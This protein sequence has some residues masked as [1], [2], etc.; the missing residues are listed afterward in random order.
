MICL[1]LGIQLIYFLLPPSSIISPTAIICSLFVLLIHYLSSSV[2]KKLLW[3]SFFLL[4][5]SPL[6]NFPVQIHTQLFALISN[7]TDFIYLFILTT[8]FLCQRGASQAQDGH[9]HLQYSITTIFTQAISESSYWRQQPKFCQ[10]GKHFRE[11]HSVFQ[12]EFPVKGITQGN[13]N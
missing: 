12:Q 7:F 6:F 2:I 11:T 5:S 9:C 3:F 1:N 13:S 8:T 10:I 4:P